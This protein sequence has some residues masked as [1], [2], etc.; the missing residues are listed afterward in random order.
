MELSMR[1][2]SAAADSAAEEEE[3]ESILNNKQNQVSNAKD[4]RECDVSGLYHDAS[5]VLN[6][7]EECDESTEDADETVREEPSAVLNARVTST[8][9]LPV[10]YPLSLF[11]KI[12]LTSLHPSAAQTSPDNDCFQSL[13][14]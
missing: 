13:S 5:N 7:A 12:I 1:E 2:L 8:G 14:R 4:F 6:N 3:V 9:R 10:V 11:M